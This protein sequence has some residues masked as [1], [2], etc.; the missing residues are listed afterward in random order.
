ALGRERIVFPRTTDKNG[1]LVTCSAYW[2]T[3]GFFP[4][5]LCLLYNETQ[6]DSLHILA[7]KY[8]SEL[9]PLKYSTVN[10]DI[11]WIINSSYGNFYR[12]YKNEYY[13][14]VIVQAAKSLTSSR[15]NPSAR[16]VRSWDDVDWI[17]ERGWGFPVNI[18]NMMNLELLTTAF[19]ISKDSSFLRIAINHADATM[20]NHFRDDNSSYHLL[21]YDPVT[22][23]VKKKLTVQG[24]ADSSSWARG[25]AW[26]LYGFTMMYRETEEL[27]YLEQAQKIAEFIV[28]H[29]NLPEDKI[30]YWDFD[31]PDIP[32]TY[33]DASA[34]AIICSALI[35]LSQFVEEKRSL[36]Y[37]SVAKQQLLT[38]SSPAYQ[39]GLGEN[40]CFILKHGV[41]ALPGGSEVDVPLLYADYYY[42]EALIRLK[43]LLQ[44][45][46]P[47]Y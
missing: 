27:R 11:G 30:P 34:G 22:G 29:P 10:H 19:K 41:G 2:W 14:G 38:L 15:Y 32:N 37:L 36:K 26:G 1:N 17:K 47:P 23:E 7:N 42:V 45:G 24:Y 31:A 20:W 12:L 4:G 5:M 43:E 35:E 25:Q 3:T 8:L 46:T 33:R 9:E 18:D 44:S 21:D 16:A 13:G 40:A 6:D 28:N 39:A